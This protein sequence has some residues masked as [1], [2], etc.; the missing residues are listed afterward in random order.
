MPAGGPPLES[1]RRLKELM[2]SYYHDVEAA[3]D[4]PD[5]L[6]AACSGLAP[7]EVVRALGIVP[8]FPENHAALIGASRQAGPYLARG[9][10]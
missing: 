2:H 3:S 7:V 6:V 4:D 10:G 5:R 1:T 8:Y 9:D